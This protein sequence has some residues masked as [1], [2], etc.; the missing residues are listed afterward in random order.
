MAGS[1]RR[2]LLWH[3]NFARMVGKTFNAGVLV[4]RKR[5][6]LVGVGYQQSHYVSQVCANVQERHYECE[7][8]RP[9]LRVDTLHL[10]ASIID[11]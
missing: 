4:E 3:A 9:S 8:V 11:R 6:E 1:F 2:L 7:P 10:H 5:R